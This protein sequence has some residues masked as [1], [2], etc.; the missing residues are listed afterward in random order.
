[1]TKT[2]L[3]KVLEPYIVKT[4]QLNT[5]NDWGFGGANKKVYSLNNQMSL[6]DGSAS[7]RHAPSQRFFNLRDSKGFIVTEK[8]K[9]IIMILSK[10]YSELSE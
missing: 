5:N 4:Q 8:L 6:H 3:L 10:D 2:Q 1:M 7:F 9:D